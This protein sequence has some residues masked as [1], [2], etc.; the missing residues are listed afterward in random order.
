MVYNENMWKR[1]QCWF[2]AWWEGLRRI[3]GCL[4]RPAYLA[5]GVA[6][7]VIFGLLLALL[8]VGTTDLGLL[9]AGVDAGVKW[10]IIGR[11]A[12]SV[13]GDPQIL[14]LTLVQT[15]QIVAL[16]RIVRQPKACRVGDVEG[17]GIVA[18]LAL[19]GVGC[20]TCGLSLLAPVLLAV[21]G[22]GALVAGSVLGGVIRVVA[23]I[24]GIVM[25]KQLGGR[26]RVAKS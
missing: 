23:L 12:L 13:V 21:F 7:F 14:L 26:I 24:V 25:I 3:V 15:L 19:L 1:T 5:L 17:V 6:V 22:S 16:A 10:G 11:A 9:F 18:I 4:R 8:S 2:V 20:P